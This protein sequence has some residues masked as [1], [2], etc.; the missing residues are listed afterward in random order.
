MKDTLA[1][2]EKLRTDAAECANL[3]SLTIDDPAKREAFNV[4]AEQLERLV[5]E[6]ERVITAAAGVGETR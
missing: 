5:A 6:M 2:W 3:G 4:L 1:R